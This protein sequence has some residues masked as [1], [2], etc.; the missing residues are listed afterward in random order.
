MDDEGMAC[1]PTVAQQMQATGL[2]NRAVCEHLE[3][4]CE[5][6]FLVKKQ[7]GFAGQRWK[8]NEYAA[9]FPSDYVLVVTSTDFKEEKGSDF[10]AEESEKA[11]T[12]TQKVVTD[13]HTN[14]S[15][16]S[17]DKNIS[18]KIYKKGKNT[19]STLAEWEKEIGSELCFAQ[20][21]KWAKEARAGEA[22]ITALISEF[23][24]KVMARGNQYADFVAAFK[25]WLRNGYL[26]KTTEQI[27]EDRPKGN[28]F[29]VWDK[30]MPL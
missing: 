27:R 18:K 8:N 4:A 22:E 30:G 15:L 10:H 29:A 20:L 9:A 24:E 3:K 21:A 7:H 14:S 6:G 13:G 1:Y 17:T 19:V 26:S 11:V 5:A 12:F 25:V 2:S 23:R 28:G 16:N